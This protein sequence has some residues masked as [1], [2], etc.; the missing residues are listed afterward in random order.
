[1]SEYIVTWTSSKGVQIGLSG[2]S[3]Y[4]LLEDD[5]GWFM[6]GTNLVLDY[7]TTHAIISR[8][9]FEPRIITLPLRVTASAQVELD[10]AID[11]LCEAFNPLYG[12]G[13]LNVV[14]HDGETT[15]EIKGVY[16]NGLEGLRSH[17]KY[18]QTW[19]LT[20]VS[21]KC[22]NH[23]WYDPMPIQATY[24]EGA[25][26]NFFPI[27]P[28]NL[29][30]GAVFGDQQVNNPGSADAWPVW[31]IDGP[32]TNPKVENLLTGKKIQLTLT[33][34]TGETLVI[35]TRPGVKTIKVGGMNKFSTAS[36]DSSLWPL[37]PGTQ[38]IK[39]TVTGASS[40]TEIRLSFNPRYL[41]L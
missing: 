4:T 23:E 26:T 7:Y 33:L 11:A 39:M 3:F 12:E 28:I 38:T 41:A 13:V 25:P 2:Q 36:A 6:P 37:V 17:D 16:W 5:A 1:M 22:P 8:V 34:L 30:A 32:A 27:F 19:Y 31:E 14:K 15:R 9:R 35:D 20:T 18:F 29:A 40:T 21:L 24:E 10:E